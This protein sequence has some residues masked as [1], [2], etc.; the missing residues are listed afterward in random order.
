MRFIIVTL[1]PEFF[2]SALSCGLLGK[3]VESELIRVSF[4]NPRD[5]AEDNHRS[6]DDRPYGGGPGMVM[7]LPPL[8]RALRSI[9]S[10]GQ[11]ILL[12]PKGKPLDQDMVQSFGRKDSLTIV[13][14]RYEGI[15]TRIEHLF[16]LQSVSVGDFVLNGGEAACLCLLESVSRLIPQFMGKDDS[17]LEESFSQGL[18]EYPHY[19]RP[20][21]FEGLKVP[22]DLLSGHHAKIKRLRRDKALE[23]T[24]RQRPDLLDRVLLTE[25]DKEAVQT[26][27]GAT[28]GRNLWLALVHH[29]VLDKRG[30]V[31]T[32]SLTNLDIHDIARVSC[33]YGLGGVALVTPLKD[34]QALALDLLQHWKEGAGRAANPDRSEALSGVYVTDDLD[35]TVTLVETQCGMRP[36]VVATSAQGPATMVGQELR[37]WLKNEPVLLLFGTGSGLAKTVLQHVDGVLKPVRGLGSYNHLSVRSAVAIVVDRLLGELG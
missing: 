12:T 13:C 23:L 4:V 28:L 20:E 7:M 5:F 34:Q 33:T 9:D 25:E 3:A 1:F 29:P 35:Q 10:P 18:L 24:T 30:R 17:A 32:H 6:V 21:E 31:T 36:K 19:T 16:P 2:A 11:M 8:V 22:E 15:D 37:R 26:E 27:R 14:G